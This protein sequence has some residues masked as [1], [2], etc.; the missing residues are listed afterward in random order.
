M[1]RRM[2]VIVLVAL[3]LAL[4][5]GALVS[6]GRVVLDGRVEPARSQG[7]TLTVAHDSDADDLVEAVP[8]SDGDQDD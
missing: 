8:T 1:T 2:G 4:L 7:H 3:V 6:A 5:S